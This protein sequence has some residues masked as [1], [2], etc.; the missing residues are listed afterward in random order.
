[1]EN[2]SI[3]LQI[4]FIIITLISVYVFYLATN[5]SKTTLV[6]ISSWMLIQLLIGLTD[7]YTKN[8]T[9]PPRF[10]LMVAP[11]LFL[12]IIIFMTNRGRNFVENLNIKL[13]TGVHILRIFVEIVLYYLFVAK[14]IPEIMTFEGRNYD[15]LVGLSAGFVLYFGLIHQYLSA[16]FII[17]WN[18]ISLGLLFNIIFYGVASAQTPFQLFGFEQPNIALAYFPFNWLPSIVV[19]IMMFSHFAVLYKFYKNKV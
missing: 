5:K 9:M 6:I 4:S 19:P 11:P 10:I 14:A 16:K 17:L 18:I 13:L 15:I 12:Q 1:M 8:T 7:F 3:L 2:V